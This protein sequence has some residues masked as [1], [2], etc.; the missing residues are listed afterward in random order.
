MRLKKTIAAALAAAMLASAVA[1]PALAAGS[2]TMQYYYDKDEDKYKTQT[3]DGAAENVDTATN[4]NLTTSGTTQV[5]YEVHSSYTW[6]IPSVID[7]GSDAGVGKTVVVN[8]VGKDDTDTVAAQGEDTPGKAMKVKV[9][10]NVI[11]YGKSLFINIETSDPK[12]YDKVNKDEADLNIGKGFFIAN[13]D[14]E[15]AQRLY[16]SIFKTYSSTDEKNPSARV[17]SWD[18]RVLEAYAGVNTASQKLIFEL[19]TE[20]GKDAEFAGTYMN[21]LTFTAEIKD[22]SGF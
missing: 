3:N 5:K 11:E 17:G 9:T 22:S 8:A 21:T 2:N 10:K 7:F 20:N 13:G 12:V 6:S 14:D 4:Q 16:F 1:V 15:D 18:E 19:H